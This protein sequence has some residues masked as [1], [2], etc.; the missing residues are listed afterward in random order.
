[1]AGL[2]TILEQVGHSWCI[3]LPDSIKVYN[4]LPSDRLRKAASDLLPGQE[5]EPP[6]LIEVTSELEYEVQE[7]LASKILGKKL[8]YRAS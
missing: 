2:Y 7:I 8:M 3:D 4:V 5:V 1:M 6:V